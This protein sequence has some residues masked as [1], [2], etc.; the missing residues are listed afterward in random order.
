MAYSLSH[1][2]SVHNRRSLRRRLQAQIHERDLALE[3]PL[4]WLEDLHR[5]GALAD[6]PGQGDMSAAIFQDLSVASGVEFSCADPYYSSE[7]YLEGVKEV[8]AGA[9]SQL[10]YDE[11][12]QLYWTTW[13]EARGMLDRFQKTRPDDPLYLQWWRKQR[14]AREKKRFGE[15]DMR[16]YRSFLFI[17]KHPGKDVIKDPNYI[18][19]TSVWENVVRLATILPQTFHGYD[20]PQYQ[21]ILKRLG[22]RVENLHGI[23]QEGKLLDVDF[24]R[25]RDLFTLLRRAWAPKAFAQ[26]QAG[27][28]YWTHRLPRV[29]YKV[30]PFAA[31]FL[32]EPVID[33]GS[34]FKIG[35]TWHSLLTMRT[36]PEVADVGTLTMALSVGESM[37]RISQLEITMVLKPATKEQ[38]MEKLR[39]KIRVLTGMA[40]SGPEFDDYRVIAQQY[41]DRLV[42]LRT[43]TRPAMFD[44]HLQVHLWHE[45]P[46][47]LSSWVERVMDA[48]T[49]ACGIGLEAEERHAFPYFL[50]Y[51]QPG[52]TRYEDPHRT[53]SIVPIE[54]SVL[55]PVAINTTGCLDPAPD[56]PVPLLVETDL[57]TPYGIDLFPLVKV[58]NFGGMGIG[59]SGSGKSNFY[60]QLILAYA[61]RDTNIVVFDGADQPSF[62]NLCNLLGGRYYDFGTSDIT[63]NPLATTIVD[64]IQQNPTTE[65]LNSMMVILAAMFRGT[66]RALDPLE[67]SI[68]T[69]A[70]RYAFEQRKDG[71]RVIL[72]HLEPGL[73]PKRFQDE[74]SKAL[75]AEFSSVLRDTWLT[76]YA[77]T[78]N[79]A[80]TFSS[81]WFSVFDVRDL[82]QAG[83][84]AL[85]PVIVAILFRFLDSLANA[86]RN[87]PLSQRRR[88]LVLIDEAW[89]AL[90]NPLL[91]E[92][93]IALYRTGR[94]RWVS[95]HLLSQN[96]E[97]VTK[98]LEM[99]AGN[100]GGE[101]RRYES[102]P[103]I[104][105]SSHIFLFKMSAQE[106]IQAE[107]TFELTER[108]R[109]KLKSLD[110]KPGEY[111]CFIHYHRVAD[112]KPNA[113]TCLRSRL[114]PEEIWATSSSAI[115]EGRRIEV[116]T[117]F[118]ELFRNEPEAIGRWQGRL[119]SSGWNLPARPPLETVIELSMLHSLSHNIAIS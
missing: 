44:A 43:A 94:A 95:P 32:L 61:N 76:R 31:Y 49:R 27:I 107:K 30:A 114:L 45:N 47:T 4:Q 56:S 62:R 11:Q 35:D 46:E 28:G 84:E 33:G 96:V 91:L 51:G 106:A 63:F 116:R 69:S 53:A 109:E 118:K 111:R 2:I 13:N 19:G 29:D 68:L 112:N 34:F 1:Q 55:T 8:L 113:F 18:G 57:G 102:S 16:M 82:F 105:Q 93:I 36:L 7:A 64:G 65:E 59:G 119:Q 39:R 48:G 80:D 40:G 100:K 67:S 75:A 72:E 77:K 37:Q 101:G 5:G 22:N 42:S 41:Q 21:N 60:Q 89:K 10:E 115:D 81:H 70:I 87:K 24:V 66:S 79:G 74:Q 104:N 78:L 97:D 103:L 71:A 88:T 3:Y 99:S 90:M 15:G 54:A 12:V 73:N 92:Q 38:E 9:L 52:Y 14:A 23:L 26:D 117:R 110:G 50:G 25:A 58:T 20:R 108:Q 17:N 6:G 98:L 83:K 86:N 85:Q